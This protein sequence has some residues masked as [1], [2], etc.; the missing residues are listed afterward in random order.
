[1]RVSLSWLRDYVDVDLPL[2]QLTNRMM[3][4]GVEVGRVERQANSW[5]RVFVGEI[6]R[7]ERHPNADRLQLATVNYGQEITVVT[8]A[9]NLSVGDRVPFAL[10]G[11]ELIDMHQNPPK[12]QKLKPSKIRGVESGGMVCSAA[13]LGLG[14][15]HSGILILDP[16]TPV[17]RPLSDVLGDTV[18]ELELT[19]NRSDCLSMLGV[20][21][22]VAALI[23]GTFREPAIEVSATGQPAAERVA[24]EIADRY[25]CRRYSGGIVEGVTV[26]PSP[27]WLQERLIAAGERPINNVVDVT[28][29]VMLEY[30]QPLHAFD[31]ATIRG[32]RIVVR[33]A[34]PG[35][36]I[37]TL[38]GVDRQLEPDMLVIADAE[39]AV[40]V[41]GVMGGEETEVTSKTTSIL[42]EAATFSPTSVRR[43]SK[44]LRLPSEA[45]RRFEKGL[46]PELTVLALARAAQLLREIGGG[47]IARGW[48]D[49]YPEPAA[50]RHVSLPMSEFERL[51]GRPYSTDEATEV[52]RRLGFGVA[53]VGDELRVDVPYRRVDVAIPADVVEEVSR[54]QGYDR[55][56]TTSL[57]G[58]MPAPT[59]PDDP[60]R[61]EERL[62]DLLVGCGLFE[63]IAYPW[64]SQTRLERVQLGATR[65]PLAQEIDRRLLPDLAALKIVNP[66]SAEAEV[67][68]TTSFVHV[69]ETVRDNLR[70]ADR[71]VRLFEIGRIYLGRGPGELP[72]E[73]RTLTIASG[74][75][76]SGE[77]WG[78]RVPL[79]FYDLKGV[80]ER[81]LGELGVP[82]VD[83]KAVEH[84]LF[85][86]GHA[87]AML[88]PGRRGVEPVLLGVL[89]EVAQVVR[90]SF[91]LDEAVFLAG[92]DLGRVFTALGEPQPVKPL[93]RYPAVLQDVALVLPETVAAE[94]V[95]RSIVRTGRPLVV[96]AAIFDVFRAERIGQ[97]K[98]SLAY[99]ITYQSAERTLTDAEVAETHRKIEAQL[100]REF[101]A[102]V[103]GR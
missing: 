30:G 84:A 33:P 101:G 18:L 83:F 68:R 11:A 23:G 97:G 32:A 86:K 44:A 99:R 56:P 60:W 93:A 90:R 102:Q 48:S 28:N 63:T 95:R 34:R 2:E 31:F 22:E 42:L 39:R 55:L 82:H 81:A 16:A 20:A 19:P 71:D 17:G 52:L 45:S 40:A 87:A 96:E 100:E 15:D 7:L 50:P 64:L 65:D 80:L 76:R 43:T 77:G 78:A 26:G 59:P 54:V 13:E 79:D 51:L 72:E 8:G 85:R 14:S 57:A 73:R 9:P 92:V 75:W 53:E 88:L 36:R 46:P 49:C 37:T 4:A 1:M 21:Q 25:L 94:D 103:R 38:D 3:L 69:L 10:V 91:D 41:A 58:R 66:L 67:L 89:G 61:L 74:A 5:E 29:Y 35:E 47:E 24:I 98:R 27:A 12:L 70:W 6:V 62:R